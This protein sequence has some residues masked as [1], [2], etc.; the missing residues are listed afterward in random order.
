MTHRAGSAVTADVI[1]VGAGIIGSSLAREIAGAGARVLVLDRGEPGAQASW[2]A[3]GMLAPQAEAD[4]PDAFFRLLLDSRSLYPAL[5]EALREETGI[6]VG[7]RTEGALLLALSEA[8][9]VGLAERFDWQRGA[10]LNVERLGA[11]EARAREPDLSPEVRSALLFAEDHQ[12][13]NRLLSRAVWI[14][15]T[16]RGAEFQLGQGVR[17]VHCGPGGCEVRLESGDRIS[18]KSVIIAAGSWSG[19][20]EGL[21][22]PLPVEPLHGQLLSL[23]TAPP[24]L[25]H[26]VGSP[27]GYMV[28]RSD[29]RLIV[30]T[31]QERTG[32][33]TAVTPRGL[34]TITAIAVEMAPGLS[35]VPVESFWSGLRPGTPDSLPI[36]G[37][38]PE[39]PGL[40][41]AT[42]HFRNGI[43][44]A[45]LTA[46][47]IGGLALGRLPEI[48]LTPFRPDRF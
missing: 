8:D 2:A 28:P 45:P 29:G 18:G 3:A 10:G 27:R 34:Q 31:T 19:L 5:A 7:Y 42:G 38:D 14:S 33:R 4:R 12:V 17:S 24:L 46:V 32:F 1:V 13:D 35:E 22:R 41:Y 47:V 16:Q 48:D 6:D 36:L 21:P 20:I 44:L 9:E 26:I 30:G 15:A 37:P 11:D 39:A 40:L 23:T 25:R 43:L